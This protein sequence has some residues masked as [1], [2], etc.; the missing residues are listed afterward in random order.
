MVRYHSHA[1]P[2]W[3]DGTFNYLDYARLTK[4]MELL[5]ILSYLVCPIRNTYTPLYDNYQLN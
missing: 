4:I 1:D 2:I 5:I 3:P